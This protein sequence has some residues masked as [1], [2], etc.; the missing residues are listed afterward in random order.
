MLEDGF[1][2]GVFT[3]ACLSC[4]KGDVAREL[5]VSV[6]LCCEASGFCCGWIWDGF[7]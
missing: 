3:I 4:F 5:V 2:E 6:E 1:G 7:E